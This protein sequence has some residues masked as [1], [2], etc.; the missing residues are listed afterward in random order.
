VVRYRW[1]GH[2]G[3]GR[4]WGGDKEEVF[5]SQGVGGQSGGNARQGISGRPVD[6][7]DIEGTGLILQLGP[8]SLLLLLLL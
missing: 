7:R 3:G 4:D 2:A 8:A 5:D 6:C 1:L